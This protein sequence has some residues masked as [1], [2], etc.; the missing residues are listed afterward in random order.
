[1][2][3]DIPPFF[4]GTVT[5][6]KKLTAAETRSLSWLVWAH[7]ILRLPTSGVRW[8]ADTLA[9][10][11]RGLAALTPYTVRLSDVAIE[12]KHCSILP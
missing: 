10:A 2:T 1:M 11:A 6:P 9:A 5:A 12:V 7:D 4:Q 3:D 8:E